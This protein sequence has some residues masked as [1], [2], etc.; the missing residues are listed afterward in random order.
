MFIE[1]TTTTWHTRLDDVA[2][3]LRLRLMD[4]PP[5]RRL[6]DVAVHWLDVCLE[7]AAKAEVALLP[8]R[9]QRAL[10]QMQHVTTA[11]AKQCQQAADEAA[12][13]HWQV[14]HDLASPRTDRDAPDLVAIAERWLQLIAP[15]LDQHQRDNPRRRYTLIG[16]ITS[17]LTADPFELGDVEEAFFGVP[18]APPLADRVSACILGVPVE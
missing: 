3:Q 14:I 12:A 4:D 18:D 15:V 13:N 17:R 7:Q 11:W 9:M 8:R 10:Q 6:D 16:D 5:N 2:D 1:P